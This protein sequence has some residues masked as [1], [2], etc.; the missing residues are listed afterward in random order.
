MLITTFEKHKQQ[1]LS[2]VPVT[3]DSPQTSSFL[4]ELLS[5]EELVPMKTVYM[6]L[7]KKMLLF[8]LTQLFST[9]ST[10]VVQIFQNLGK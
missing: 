7:C 2:L 3:L 4:L 10:S 9:E 8:N 6:L 5:T 1:H